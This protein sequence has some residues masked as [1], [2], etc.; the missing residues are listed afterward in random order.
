AWQN[1]LVY[2]RGF[3]IIRCTSRNMSVAFLRLFSTG[4]PIE[5]LGTNMPSITSK[6]SHS[7][8]AALTSSTSRASFAKS[9]DRTDGAITAIFFALPAAHLPQSP[10]QRTC[11]HTTYI[12]WIFGLLYYAENVFASPSFTF[13]SGTDTAA[14]YRKLF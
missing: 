4:I 10:R 5:M 2:L 7:A 12:I 14:W 3:S 6:C 9:A 1:C 8:P 11:E 13:R